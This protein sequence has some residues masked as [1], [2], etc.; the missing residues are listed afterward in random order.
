VIACALQLRLSKSWIR[1]R[2]Y[3]ARPP[4][5]ES[6]SSSNSDRGLRPRFRYVYEVRAWLTGTR[7]EQHVSGRTRRRFSGR[8][9]VAP[10]VHASARPLMLRETGSPTRWII[11]RTVARCTRA[12]GY[13]L[14]ALRRVR[15]RKRLKEAAW[16]Q[17][18]RDAAAGAPRMRSAT[19]R[20]ARLVRALHRGNDSGA[21]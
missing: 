1:D 15:L 21:S 8:S 10:R 4:R 11:Y 2:S 12:L 5:G 3:V 6:R 16:K 9:K 13:D 20:H 19:H 18:A 14:R 7:A 17:S